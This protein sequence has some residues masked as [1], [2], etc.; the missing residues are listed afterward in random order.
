MLARVNPDAEVEKLTE[1]ILGL[2][3]ESKTLLPHCRT[4]YLSTR[5]EKESDVLF[6]CLGSDETARLNK[7]LS[8]EID[9]PA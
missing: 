4:L 8:F 2:V 3:R 9:G 5:D 1:A 6:D 7:I